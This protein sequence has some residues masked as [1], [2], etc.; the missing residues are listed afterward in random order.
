MSQSYQKIGDVWTDDF[1]WISISHVCEVH[2]Y[3]CAL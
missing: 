1:E 2:V 3:P